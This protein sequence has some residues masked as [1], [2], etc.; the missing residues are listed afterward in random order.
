MALHLCPVIANFCVLSLDLIVEIVERH[1]ERHALCPNDDAVQVPAV[2]RIDSVASED[3]FA[4]VGAIEDGNI[5]TGGIP[6]AVAKSRCY[7]PLSEA[8]IS[9][10]SRASE[11]CPA[12][13]DGGRIRAQ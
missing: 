5:G 2:F 12:N 4:D 8:R 10:G 1:G 7:P 6:C 3:V 11:R 13:Y 9:G